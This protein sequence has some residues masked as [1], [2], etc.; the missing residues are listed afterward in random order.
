M[1]SK[2]AFTLIELLV[3][4]AIIAILAGL[5]LPAIAKV[6]QNLKEKQQ[7]EQH[8]IISPTTGDTFQ[9]GDTVVM[10][11]MDVTGRVNAV[12]GNGVVDLLVRSTNGTV[13]AIER[14]NSGLLKKV[15]APWR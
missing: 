9:I 2:S 6:K 4:I 12:Y 5:L 14:V 15:P 11:G 3:V 7:M 1:K 13:S 8:G 10:D